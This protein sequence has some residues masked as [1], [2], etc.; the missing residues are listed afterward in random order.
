MKMETFEIWRAAMRVAALRKIAGWEDSVVLSSRLAELVR[1]LESSLTRMV[2]LKGAARGVAFLAAHVL[3]EV[4]DLL[5]ECRGSVALPVS[6]SDNTAAE[7]EDGGENMSEKLGTLDLAPEKYNFYEKT[8]RNN[9]WRTAQVEEEY[10]KHKKFFSFEKNGKTIPKG[11]WGIVTGYEK[12]SFYNKEEETPMTFHYLRVEYI[13]GTVVIKAP[14]KPKVVEAERQ[15]GKDR[16]ESVALVRLY[17]NK[18]YGVSIADPTDKIRKE[19]IRVRVVELKNPF[20]RSYYREPILEDFLD[21]NGMLRQPRIRVRTYY[22]RPVYIREILE[23]EGYGFTIR[24]TERKLT[25]LYTI[26]RIGNQ[27]YLESLDDKILRDLEKIRHKIHELERDI[28]YIETEKPVITSYEFDDGTPDSFE[29]SKEL[30]KKLVLYKL[31][32]G[33]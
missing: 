26:E 21:K 33:G 20:T 8:R 13:G 27:K 29:L 5:G 16:Y 18:K 7:T 3:E 24:D 28:R 11:N 12:H 32:G 17:W 25:P 6:S 1:E 10:G 2:V 30:N 22:Y 14:F 9:E 31:S 23:R 19:R 15:I 4:K